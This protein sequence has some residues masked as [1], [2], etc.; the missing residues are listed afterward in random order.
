MMKSFFFVRHGRTEWNDAGRYLGRSDIELNEVG[1]AQAEHLGRWA[2]GAAIEAI[3]SSPAQRAI[4][5]ANTIGRWCGVRVR[6]DERL[7]EIDFG[8]AEGCTLEELRR[9]EPDAVARFESDPVA[10]AFPGGESPV[11]AVERVDAALRDALRTDCDR[12]LFVSHNTLLRLYLCHRMGI[13]LANYRRCLSEIDHRGYTELS[14]INGDFRLER[15][16]A[17][18]AEDVAQSACATTDDDIGAGR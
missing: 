12:M 16:N 9:S 8:I 1:Q 4:M 2:V 10:D 7:R 13:S 15:F 11:A 14:Q 3:V 18:A 5:T 6:V 17:P